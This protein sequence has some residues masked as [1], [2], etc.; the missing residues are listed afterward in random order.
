[1]PY[2]SVVFSFIETKLFTQQVQRYL[3]DD[4]YQALQLQ[5]MERPDA[6]DVIPGAGGVRKLRWK[7]AGRGKRSGYRAIY[8]AKVQQGMIWMLTMYS[9]NIKDDIPIKTL[10]KIAK[11]V[12]DG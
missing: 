7:A 11:E 2:N 12:E 3:S 4:D 10:R 8:F 5:L 6:G 9:K 1:V